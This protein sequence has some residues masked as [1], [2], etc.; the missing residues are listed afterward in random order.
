[1]CLRLRA[2]SA[3]TESTRA[4]R[5]RPVLPSG[6][7]QT[8]CPRTA[9]R[10]G[11]TIGEGRDVLDRERQAISTRPEVAAVVSPPRAEVYREATVEPVER[12]ADDFAV[13]A[14]PFGYN[15]REARCWVICHRAR[16]PFIIRTRGSIG[17]PVYVVDL[18]KVGCFCPSDQSLDPIV[19]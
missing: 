1:M 7:E 10:L 3:S 9:K 5:A 17:L 6:L 16:N 2:L 19:M 11:K 12:D 18:A 15:D 4:L 8:K 14:R 13:I